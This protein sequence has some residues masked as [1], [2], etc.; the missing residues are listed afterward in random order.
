M[1]IYRGDHLPEKFHGSAVIPEAAGNLVR[2]APL[3]GDGVQ[4]RG[5]NA[6]ERRELLASTDERFR[7]VCSRTG[8]DGAIYICD[9]YR[10]I[11][12]HVIFMM[13]YLR[14]QI[15]SRGLDKPVGMG[16]IYRIVHGGRHSGKTAADVGAG[17]G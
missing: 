4:V 13:P 16:R 15:L 14:H 9:L 10:G 12:E 2:L 7:P 3:T 5:G 8:P 6:F 1:S 17:F 11:I